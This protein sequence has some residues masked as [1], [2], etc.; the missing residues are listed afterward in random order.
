MNI[1]PVLIAGKKF[2]KTIGPIALEVFLYILKKKERENEER[3]RA[4]RET[5]K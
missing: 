1:K 3:E 2:G 5:K 4:Q